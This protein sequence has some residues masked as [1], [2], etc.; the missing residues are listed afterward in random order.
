MRAT[1]DDAADVR[2][3]IVVSEANEVVRR[4]LLG[5]L[6]SIDTVDVA[7][8]TCAADDALR[9]MREHDDIDMLIVGSIGDATAAD[10]AQLVVDQGD[11]R[12]LVLV[13]SADPGHLRIAVGIQAH[14]Y[15]VLS[16]LTTNA[17]ASALEQVQRAGMFIPPEVGSHLLTRARRETPEIGRLESYLSPRERDVLELLVSGQSNGDISHSLGI[18]IHSAKRHVSSILTKL[19]SPSRTHLV[20]Q[21]L[22][23]R[24]S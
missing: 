6:R 11:A 23:S 12:V 18:S 19:A 2:L 8:G 17:L 4:G 15:L 22:Q 16:D 20:S 5:M 24:L 7:Y 10:A 9:L 21:V 13:P 1:V 14:G 3:Q